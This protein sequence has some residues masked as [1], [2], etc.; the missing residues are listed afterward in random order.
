[1]GHDLSP[2]DLQSIWSWNK[3]VPAS[4]QRCVH[5]MIAERSQIQPEAPAVCAWDGDLTYLELDQRATS[6]AAQ[7]INLGIH[8][9]TLVP[10]CFE[11]SKWVTVAMLGVLKAGGGI[12]LLDPGLPEQRLRHMVE[13]VDSGI[14]LSSVTNK[15]LSSRLS[16]RVVEVGPGLPK[17][18][19]SVPTACANPQP[20]ST[21]MFAVFTS[22]STGNPKGVVLTHENFCSS[23]GYQL[24]LLKFLPESRVFDFASWVPVHSI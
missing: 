3:A 15:K 5:E 14:L 7:L 23:V 19:E 12:V 18:A 4:V 2:H 16:K 24:D 9:D 13:Q 20:P 10:L 21:A 8:A 22:G 6:L 1:M 11:K 17:P